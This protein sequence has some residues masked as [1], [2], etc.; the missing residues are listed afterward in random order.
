MKILFFLILLSIAAVSCGPDIDLS[1][2]AAADAASDESVIDEPEEESTSLPC[3]GLRKLGEDVRVGSEP[4]TQVFPSLVWT[5]SEYAVAAVGFASGDTGGNILLARISADGAVV[6]SDIQVSSSGG[7][8]CAFNDLAWTGS[9][10]GA[11]WHDDRDGAQRVYFA[12][13]GCL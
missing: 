6:V 3:A 7:G 8:T 9:E 11:A 5:G 13:V 2:D 12:R 4:E 10:L 1:G